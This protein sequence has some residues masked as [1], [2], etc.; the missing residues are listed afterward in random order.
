MGSFLF[1]V[2][3]FIVLVLF[4][5]AMARKV[6]SLFRSP[7]NRVRTSGGAPPRPPSA[8]P[9]RGEMARDPVCGMFVSTELSQQLRRGADT[10]HFCSRECLEKYQKDPEHVAS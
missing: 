3:D 9:H 7:G 2:L 1:E 8:T 5:V 6:G 4:L 10:L